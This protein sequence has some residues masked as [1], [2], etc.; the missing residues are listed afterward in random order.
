MEFR[1]TRPSK[2]DVRYLRIILND[3]YRLEYEIGSSDHECE[4]L[5]DIMDKYGILKDGNGL[6]MTIDLETGHVLEWPQNKS[7][8]ID[9][10]NL[11][12]VDEGCYALLDQNMQVV[13]GLEY[14]GYVPDIIGEG[15]YGDYWMFEVDKDGNIPGWEMTQEKFDSF[16]GECEGFEIEYKD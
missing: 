14:R 1:I 10:Y 3:D 16:C 5:Q 15:G 13:C 7:I 11:K 4:T 2:I 9:F 6:K 8:S 12:I